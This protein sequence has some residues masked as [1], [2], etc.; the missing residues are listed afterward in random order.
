MGVIGDEMKVCGV[1]EKI[2][3]NM[4]GKDTYSYFYPFTSR[5]PLAR[6]KTEDREKE[7][8]YFNK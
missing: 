5:P 8:K 2:V 1:D 6:D 4:K 7:E 3:M